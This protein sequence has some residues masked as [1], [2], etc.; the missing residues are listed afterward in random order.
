MDGHNCTLETLWEAMARARKSNK[1]AASQAAETLSETYKKA[2][3]EGS[4]TNSIDLS[5]IIN[6]K[7][8]TDP[9][10]LEA[11]YKTT[12][13]LTNNKLTATTK[14]SNEVLEQKAAQWLDEN[15]SEF[16]DIMDTDDKSTIAM[17]L[18]KDAKS[19]REVMV[20]QL[21][22]KNISGAIAK[23]VEKEMA[24][25]AAANKEYILDLQQ[26]FQQIEPARKA[27]AREYGR[28]LQSLKRPDN[29]STEVGNVLFNSNPE[30][31][32]S[33]LR[34]ATN[35]YAIRKILSNVGETLTRFRINSMLASPMTFAV[36][37]TGN[38]IQT[39]IRPLNQAIGAGLLSP[40][41][42]GGMTEAKMAINQ[43]I[44]MAKAIGDSVRLSAAAL[45]RGPVLKGEGST[46]TAIPTKGILNQGWQGIDPSELVK[47]SPADAVKK[48]WEFGWKNI[49][50]A[51]NTYIDLP[52]TG[53]GTADE[54]FLQL[55]FRGKL[56]AEALHD[57]EVAGIAPDS[58]EF[59]TFIKNRFNTSLSDTGRA[60]PGENG[61]GTEALEYAN[62][63]T[64]SQDLDNNQIIGNVAN[65]LM[66]FHNS[67][68]SVTSF[69]GKN[70]LSFVKTPANLI[71]EAVD[72]IPVA[73]Q[74]P[75]VGTFW[76]E[77][78]KGGTA[79]AEAVG[80]AVVGASLGA[81]GFTAALAGKLTGSG[82]KDP[83]ARALLKKEQWQPY[84]IVVDNPDGTKKFT[85]ISRL[86]P[87]SKPLMLLADAAENWHGFKDT[88]WDEFSKSIA[89]SFT[90]NMVNRSYLSGGISAAS[91][92]SDIQNGDD[93]AIE[94]Y[95]STVAASF[96][97]NYVKD[98]ENLSDPYVRKA[99]NIL[100]AVRA[101][102]PGQ[103]VY[104]PADRDPTGQPV[105]AAQLG[106]FTTTTNDIVDKKFMEFAS[107]GVG[108]PALSPK[109]GTLDLREFKDKSG[110][111]AFDY[112]GNLIYTNKIDGDDPTKPT[113][114]LRDILKNMFS[115]PE[116]QKASKPFTSGEE[117]YRGQQYYLISN[118]ISKAHRASFYGEGGLMF[119]KSFKNKQ[120]QTIQQAMMLDKFNRA[121]VTEEAKNKALES[122][123]SDFQD[124][125][126]PE[127]LTNML[128][129]LMNPEEQ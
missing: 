41:G 55:N 17:N 20:R 39:L 105:L 89:L 102:I 99:S 120:G 24:L 81:V 56:Y 61:A 69:L 63:S 109:V 68:N 82:P 100:D 3:S 12:V 58:P 96:V 30:Q 124:M 85:N 95:F 15:V 8:F 64:F 91:M 129:S 71:Q 29:L 23:E 86:D 93:K 25:G 65:L 11:L 75:K 123:Q 116:F 92:L 42:K 127:D 47:G 18:M 28:G 19:L 48:V 13:E 87:W 126:N 52:S 9:D 117:D 59:N 16:A 119:N 79:R 43:Y 10:S 31:L 44:G 66:G 36:N 46:L 70:V 60:L 50:A 115:D 14:I 80:K 35:S 4:D 106:L 62:K 101:R 37:A 97:P 112:Y 32:M 78:A 111:S 76:R 121:L 38:T 45:A 22:A 67:P 34:L 125:S 51:T 6:T 98:L 88:E 104:V 1:E 118:T 26:A 103:S 74:V 83:N 84:S 77:Y 40:L 54:L 7:T 57:A 122:Q 21:V 114:T 5:E 110:K 72:Y 94:R 73:G 49:F 107:Q 33:D 128:D 27:V 108:F 90:N 113:R 53:L 2:I